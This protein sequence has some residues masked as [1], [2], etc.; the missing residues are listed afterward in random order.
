M[1]KSELKS[2]VKSKQTFIRL[3]PSNLISLTGILLICKGLSR[4]FVGGLVLFE[5]DCS[6]KV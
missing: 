2:E 5:N 6:G 1:D 4:A 3:L